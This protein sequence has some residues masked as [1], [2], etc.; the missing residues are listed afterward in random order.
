[1]TKLIRIE[2]KTLEKL[3]KKKKQGETNAQALERILNE[4]LDVPEG[5]ELVGEVEIPD[6]LIKKDT[7]NPESKRIPINIFADE[8][9]KKRNQIVK[10]IIG[11]KGKILFIEKQN[12]DAWQYQVRNEI[13]DDILAKLEERQTEGW[14]PLGVG[15]FETS[16][17]SKLLKLVSVGL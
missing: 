5:Y 13:T 16:P 15:F 6:H 7:K 12:G 10:E 17:D 2:L 1:M 4:S 14:K 3:T 8:D 11:I 9:L